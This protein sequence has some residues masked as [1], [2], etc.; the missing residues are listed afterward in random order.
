MKTFRRLLGKSFRKATAQVAFVLALAATQAIAVPVTT[1]SDLP[2]ATAAAP[3][4]FRALSYV[5][6][7]SQH[8]MVHLDNPRKEEVIV[9]VLNQHEQVMYRKSFGW[10][11]TF[12]GKFSLDALPNG[13]YTFV[14]KGGRDSYSKN[15]AVKTQFERTVQVL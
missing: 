11:A 3:G 14:V 2:P 1:D 6:S 4:E 13:N 10:P 15:I 5:K 12:V 7:D 8:L 9:L